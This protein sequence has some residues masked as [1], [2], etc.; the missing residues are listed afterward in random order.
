[1]DFSVK[2]QG[3]EKSRKITLGLES[4]GNYKLWSWEVLV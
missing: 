4:S 3:N 2:F 1:V